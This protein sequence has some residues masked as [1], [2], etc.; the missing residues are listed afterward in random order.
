[1]K[2]R[3]RRGNLT[4]GEDENHENGHCDDLEQKRE[5][6]EQIGL[7]FLQCVVVISFHVFTFSLAVY[8]HHYVPATKSTTNKS[9]FA[10]WRARAH[11]QEITSYG[12]RP[13]GSYANENQTVGYLLRALRSIKESSSE[14]IAL[15][16]DVQRPSGT[17]TLDFLEGFTS[18]YRNVSNVV[19]RLSSK[20]NYP[21]E[22]SVL[23]NAHFDTA[24]GGA[25]ASDD[26][27]SCA[28]MLEVIRCIAQ[29]PTAHLHHSLVF[30]FNGAEE[31][32]LQASH[33]FI[34]QHRWAKDVRVFVN[35]EAAGAG[36]EVRRIHEVTK[37]TACV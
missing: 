6:H 27:V 28:A 1:M 13:A 21:A 31:N 19:A 14:G 11:L 7:T 3:S 32:V 10:E 37:V 35:L 9:D 36:K 16:I 4:N 34:T 30:L 29:S 26:A 23:V 5:T 18:H 33:G 22:H 8:A 25:G 20:E 12:R 17:F 2:V 15:D 24:F